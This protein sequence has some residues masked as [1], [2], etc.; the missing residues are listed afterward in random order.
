MRLALR[1]ATLGY[2]LPGALIAIGALKAVLSLP[3]DIGANSL[4]A[5]GV[6]LLVYVY[7]LRFLTVGYN[8]AAAGLAQISPAMDDAARMLGLRPSGVVARLHTPIAFRSFVAGALVIFIDVAKELPATLILRPFNFET[9]ATRTYRLASDE[10]LREAAPDAL[11]LI[12]LGA[13]P[14]IIL[15]LTT[16]G[17]ARKS[18][19]STN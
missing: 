9:L 8:Y 19:K 14:V 10:R 18:V 4:V 3:G 17:A 5:T 2:A 16:L 15:A 6:A 11:A 13:I 1:A 12:M 7:V